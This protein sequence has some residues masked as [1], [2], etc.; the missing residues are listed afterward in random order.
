MNIRER[1]MAAIKGHE[2]DVIP[3]LIYSNLLPRGYVGRKLRNKGLGL[4][5]GGN[6]YK[7]TMPN[8]SVEEKK[9]GDF[10]YRKY[11]TPVGEVSEKMKINLKKGTGGQWRVEYMIKRPEDY[12]VVKFIVEDVVYEPSY[13]DFLEVERDL[14]EDGVVFGWVGYTPLMQIIVQFMGYQKFAVELYRNRE[15]LEDLIKV[16]DRRLEE[17]CHIV[18]ESP[19]EIIKVGDNTD[20][21]LIS[22][23]LFEDYC[24]PY[25]QKYSRI[26]H[27]KGKIVMSHMDGRLKILKHLI[28]KTGLDMIEA[29]T[30]PPGGDLPI[31]EARKA[32]GEDMAIWINVPEVVFFYERRKIEEYVLSLLREMAPGRRFLFGI[33]EDIPETR[34]EPGLDALISTIQ[35]YGKYPLMIET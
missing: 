28:G 11:H 30:P 18:A 24:L 31:S 2:P 35:K 23:K 5:V 29:F 33:T 16:I 32:W 13:R 3:C 26:L 22:P 34:L 6:V 15:E 27:S 12:E 9:V 8:V 14:G 21:M 17:V 4:T 1:T 19:A 7:T 25:F 10:L 20:S